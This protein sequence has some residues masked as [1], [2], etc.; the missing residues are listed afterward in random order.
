[1]AKFLQVILMDATRSFSKRGSPFSKM[2][3]ELE[4][5]HANL[6]LCHLTIST[7]LSMV[8]RIDE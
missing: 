4:N 2:G 8:F 5:P 7:D 6:Y 3:G 1:M